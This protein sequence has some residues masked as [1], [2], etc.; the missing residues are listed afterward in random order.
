MRIVRAWYIASVRAGAVSRRAAGKKLAYK[1]AGMPPSDD[2]EL[3]QI[4]LLGGGWASDEGV[5]AALAALAD[6]E[7]V[8]NP[9]LALSTLRAGDFDLVVTDAH[10]LVEL[11]RLLGYT[12][13][14]HFLEQVDQCAGIINRGGDLTWANSKLRSF[15]PHVVETLR[16]A[17]HEQL[18]QFDAQ[19]SGSDPV[20]VRRKAVAIDGGYVFDVTLSARM[21]AGGA[22]EQIVMLGWDIT[23]KQRLQETIDAIDAAGS[24]LVGIDAENLAKLDVSERLELLEEKIIDLSHRLLHYDNFVIRVLDPKTNRLDTLLASGLSEEAQNLQIHA[25]PE[26]NGIIG[27]VAATGQSYICPDITQDAKYLPGLDNARSSLTVPLE[28]NDRI[29]GVLDI[30]SEQPNAFSAHDRQF[31]EIF[32]RHIAVALHI[33]K[34]L[35]VERHTTTGQLAADVDAEMAEPLNDIVATVTG[36]LEQAHLSDEQRNTLR[37]IIDKVDTVKDA[38]HAVTES[39]GIT[40]LI[41][42][43]EEQDEVLAG[44]RILV[45]D[46]EDIIRETIGDVLRKAGANPMLASEG[47]EAVAMLRSQRFEL[48]LSD[49]KMPNRNGYEVFAAAREMDARCPVILITGFGYDPDHSIVRASKE[50]LAG[51]LFKPFKVEQLLEEVRHALSQ[52]N[53][54]A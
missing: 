28:M 18:T 9:E 53:P 3:R 15:P 1:G 21:G 10:Q 32:G 29:I 14:E 7:H 22:V 38:V 12:R 50:G 34:L 47:N 26:D 44:K 43:P 13:T 6:V 30:E 23:E 4:L 17:A 48:V 42:V 41:H 25:E 20:R 39:T 45:A 31:A 5:R 2:S 52:P 51:V 40:G 19:D 11:A 54:Q 49:I 35:A 27:W 46:D 37:S 36:L 8:E 16:A 33:M 24:E